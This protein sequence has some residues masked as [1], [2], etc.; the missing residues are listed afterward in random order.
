[1]YH[2]MDK[3]EQIIIYDLQISPQ[4]HH[5]LIYSLPISC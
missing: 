1:M 5:K 2:T 4:N 3:S